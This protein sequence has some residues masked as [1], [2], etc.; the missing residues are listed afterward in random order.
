MGCGLAEVKEGVIWP[1]FGVP[2][3]SREA[4]VNFLQFLI[5]FR[6]QSRLVQARS[7]T[8]RRLRFAVLL[9]VLSIAMMAGLGRNCVGASL[10]EVDEV[11]QRLIQRSQSDNPIQPHGAYLCTKQ[12]LTEEMDSQGRVTERK[13]KVRETESRPDGATAANKWGSE[14]GIGLDAQ[15]LRR[16]H[17]S[18]LK[19]EDINGRPAL[20]LTF[21][22]K[23]P[24]APVRHFQDRLLNRAMGTLWV[25]E[26][27]YELVKANICLGEPVS[28]G[29][30]GAV[31][32]LNFAFERERSDSGNWLTHWTETYVKA[33]KFLKPIQTR[34]RVDWRDFRRLD[35]VNDTTSSEDEAAEN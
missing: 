33:R 4:S 19:R 29:I 31:D 14:N 6:R 22:P 15:L 3:S 8:M 25:D 32:A 17:F 1:D 16:Y 23:V 11:L 24:P 13:V 20:L 35:Q 30:F 2:R 28:F 26:E 10:P 9:F 5:F 12:T 7:E 27:D 21:V 34:K 18:L